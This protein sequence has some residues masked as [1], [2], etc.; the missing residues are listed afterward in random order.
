MQTFKD[1]PS[2]ARELMRVSRL[3]HR[4]GWVPATS[5]N[6]SAKLDENHLAITVSGQDKGKLSENGIMV[7]DLLGRPVTVDRTPSAETQLHTMLYRRD[8]RIG[9]VLHTHSVNATVLS[10]LHQEGLQLSGYEVLKAL[11]RIASH[12]VQ[13]TV[14]IF[15]NDQNIQRLA[16]RVTEYLD[17]HSDIPG[18][19]IAGHGFYTWGVSVAEAM[20]HVEAFEFLFQ[21]E[22][23][24]RRIAQR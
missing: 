1:F 17:R 9:A 16:D 4:L 11:P 3:C 21:C 7:V 23:L 24:M 5:G 15:A 6:F 8:S 20:R 22:V 18:Y 14:P 2:R 10:Q 13:V 19:L 12:Q